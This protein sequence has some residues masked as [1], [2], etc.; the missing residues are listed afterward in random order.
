MPDSQAKLR[1]YLQIIDSL[2]MQLSQLKQLL[3]DPE[4]RLIGSDAKFQVGGQLAD[5]A[6]ELE[7]LGK[8]IESQ[9]G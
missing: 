2:S 1:P 6:E 3:N 9:E 8:E 5:L 7:N 4:Q